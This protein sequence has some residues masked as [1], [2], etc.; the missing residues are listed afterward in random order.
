MESITLAVSVVFALIVY[1]LVGGLIRRWGILSQENFKALNGM[2]FRIFIPLTLF[3][4]VYQADLKESIQGEVFGFV[5]AAVLVTFAVCW[6]TVSRMVRDG[7]DAA[8]IIQGMYRS[9]YVLFGNYV[10][11]SLCGKSGIALVAALAALVVP[12]F[13]ILAVILFECK[14]GGSLHLSEIF[15]NICKNPLVEAGVLGCVFQLLHIRIPEL[16]LDPLMTLGEIATPLA[17]VTLGGLLSF[18]SLLRH[19]MYLL[20][21]NVIRLVVIPLM[22]LTAAVLLGMRGEVLVAVLAIFASPT[23]VASAPMAQA[24]GGNGALA[25]EIVATTTTFCIGSIFLFVFGLSS[26][27]L[28]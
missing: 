9:N 4:N 24:M 11:M 28:L 1:M 3:F 16:L 22:W 12:M 5:F 19:R 8:T 7:S 15:I 25:G 23:A 10:A 26:L 6:I 17:L 2:V 14:R 21:I 27:G 18:D 20:V 13:N